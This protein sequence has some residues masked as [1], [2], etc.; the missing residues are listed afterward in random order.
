MA[1]HDDDDL[2]TGEALIRELS[3]AVDPVAR[4]HTLDELWDC[5][6][7]LTEAERYED[8]LRLLDPLLTWQL[9]PERQRAADE[10]ADEEIADTMVGRADALRNLDRQVEVVAQCDDLIN[11]F[12]NA[13][14]T[15]DWLQGSMANAR[16]LHG[17][18]NLS[19][20]RYLDALV[21]FDALIQRESSVPR[22]DRSWVAR[23]RQ[24][25][26]EAL[27][28]LG[29]EAGAAEAYAEA[30]AALADD[31]SR[32]TLL[33]EKMKFDQARLLAR[34]GRTADA[35][36][37]CDT[38]I[39]LP[40]P[41]AP[42]AVA[43]AYMEKSLSLV[44]RQDFEAAIATADAA[45]QRFGS[46]EDTTIRL[47]VAI[48]LDAKIIALTALGNKD[49]AAFAADQL[50]ERFGADLDPSIENVVAP[51]AHR[52]GRRRSRLRFPGIG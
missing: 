23:A 38:L 49:A 14:N 41:R 12:E 33:V 28:G 48:C 26:A 7:R 37:V 13:E 46:S 5:H 10:V 1:G 50:V 24:E 31:D 15:S 51:H 6:E 44:E 43:G 22:D 19:L 20:G 9:D 35:I 21:A 27:E 32:L 29:D 34:L 42:F 17:S 8:A 45:V 4:D 36:A 18:G 11:R 52:L 40:E 3:T 39:A 25:R 16:F 47:C 30:I 2:A